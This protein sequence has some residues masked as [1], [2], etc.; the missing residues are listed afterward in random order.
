MD[1][2]PA[3]RRP[4]PTHTAGEPATAPAPAPVAAVSEP[5]G[6]ASA[7]PLPAAVAPEPQQ[8]VPAPTRAG[9]ELVT[10]K[11]AALTALEVLGG[12][13]AERRAA[14]LSAWDS[15]VAARTAA[16]HASEHLHAAVLE[17]VESQL[18]A[19]EPEASAPEASAPEAAPRPA[20]RP[21]RPCAPNAAPSP[22]I[23]TRVLSLVRTRAQMTLAE[24]R[25]A[26]PDVRS[27]SISKALHTLTHIK[28]A[29]ERV[30]E[31]TYRAVRR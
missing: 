10:R 22:A 21:R 2:P 30:A 20:P 28:H 8:L 9:D 19:P 23:E 7:A 29:L 25:T 15:C 3:F 24:L 27:R 14:L 5:E 17:A 13:S 11:R 26:M 6:A 18:G 1:L 16:I 12:F 4:P 31:G